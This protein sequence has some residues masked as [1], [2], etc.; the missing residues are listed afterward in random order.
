MKIEITL[1]DMR[2]KILGMNQTEFAAQ[3]G[4]SRRTLVRYENGD[5]PE[6]ALLLAER[7]MLDAIKQAKEKRVT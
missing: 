4:V 3:L 5:V 7:I 1:R 6:T 2:K